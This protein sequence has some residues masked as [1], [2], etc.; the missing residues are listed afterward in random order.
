MNQAL[1]ND[2]I[3]E[4]D[5][6]RAR[7]LLEPAND[8]LKTR[9]GTVCEAIYQ[10][11]RGL[12]APVRRSTKPTL[13]PTELNKAVAALEAQQTA[14]RE[15]ANDADSDAHKAFY[16]SQEMAVAEALHLARAERINGKPFKHRPKAPPISHPPALSKQMA[17]NARVLKLCEAKLPIRPSQVSDPSLLAKIIKFHRKRLREAEN[18]LSE[19]QKQ[20]T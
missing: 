3:K 7:M 2:L 20:G 12:S 6:I 5:D 19:L 11:R 1:L 10:T 13:T 8:D 4:R 16:R 14:L 15:L 17:D 9:E 18:R